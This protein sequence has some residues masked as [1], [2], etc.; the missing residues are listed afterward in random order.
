MASTASGLR[1][2]QGAAHR[3]GAEPGREPQGDDE[4][5]MGRGV[6]QR[7]STARPP[8]KRPSVAYRRFWRA[9]RA[10]QQITCIYGGHDRVVCPIILGYSGDGQEAV[11]A[12]QIGGGSTKK[13]PPA[14]DWRCFHLADV[15][16]ISLR[17]GEWQSGTRH[18][19][20]QSCVRYVDV[21]VN[22]PETLTRGRPL[23]FR[24]PELR[25]PR[26]SQ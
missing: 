15:T 5:V 8:S 21:D 1:V 13:L 10:H 25:P 12:F 4:N 26:R 7:R 17:S 14:G 2:R 9:V 11:F 16:D 23:A 22:I 6:V 24:S 19:R 3:R 18:T 20:P